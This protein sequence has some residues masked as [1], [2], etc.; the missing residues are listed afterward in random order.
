MPTALKT[1]ASYPEDGCYSASG[2]IP[3][4]SGAIMFACTNSAMITSA[5]TTIYTVDNKVEEIKNIDNENVTHFYCFCH[6]NV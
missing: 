3:I 4:Y 1:H 5:F 2:D 6:W